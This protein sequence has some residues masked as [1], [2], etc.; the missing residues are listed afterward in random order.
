MSNIISLDNYADGSNIGSSQ[1]VMLLKKAL[2]A[3][4]QAG[5]GV[6]SDVL[7]VQS[8]E[9]TLKN[10]QYKEKDIA[11]WML[12]PKK[13]ATSTV[14]EYN[15]LNS[16]GDDSGGSF[17]EGDAPNGVDASYSRE[18][19]LV[20]YYGVTK[21]VTHAAQLVSTN[22]GDMKVHAAMT[23]TRWLLR[24]VDRSLAMA[25]ASTI[26]TEINGFLQ[27]HRNSFTSLSGWHNSDFVMDIRGKRLVEDDIEDG[28][29][30]LVSQGHAYPDTLIGAPV[31][32]SGFVKQYRESKFI[33]PNSPQITN[34]IM[35]QRVQKFESQFSSID[36][37]YDKFL[38][39][40]PRKTTDGATD[41]AAPAAP[42]VDGTTPFTVVADSASQFLV[43]YE[44]DYFIGVAAINRNGMSPISMFSNSLISI[45]A[46]DAVDLKF[47]AGV[48]ANAATGYVIFRSEVDPTGAL[49]DTQLWPIFEVSLTELAAGYDGGAAGIIRDRNRIIPNTYIAFLTENDEEVWAIKQLAPLMRMDLARVGT[50]DR[51]MILLYFTAQLYAPKKMMIYKNIGVRVP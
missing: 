29:E 2:E 41:T 34:G 31:V 46:T 1:D 33:Q 16:Y 47:A 7:K 4:Y 21:T 36:L 26:P 35:G 45:S 13:E 12:V 10:T 48:G 50:A 27:L 17:V 8:L 28:S 42:V 37:Q 43:D 51:F 9:K 24:K 15:R 40:T 11:F 5:T 14:E 18:V 3:G 20:K 32:L 39:Q 22:V 23:G 38:R 25:S 49:A 44:G 19:E 6:S 30:V